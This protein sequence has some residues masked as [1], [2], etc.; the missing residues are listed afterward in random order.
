[1]FEDEHPLQDSDLGGGKPD[2]LGV[3]HHV[4]HPL[5]EL[6][7]IVVELVTSFAFIRSATSGYWRI[8]LSA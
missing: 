1:M 6:R 7:Q 5:G 2:A 8:W 4:H 3:G